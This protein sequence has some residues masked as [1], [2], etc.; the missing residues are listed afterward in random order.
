M[1]GLVKRQGIS[2]GT[3]VGQHLVIDMQR[4]DTTQQ[5]ILITSRY[6]YDRLPDVARNSGQHRLIS[7][8]VTKFNTVEVS[9]G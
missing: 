1:Q 4:F 8:R 5:R 2:H 6:C 9:R 3:G 7:I